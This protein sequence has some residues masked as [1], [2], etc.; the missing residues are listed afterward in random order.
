VT[1]RCTS[2]TT[3]VAAGVV[4]VRDKVKHRTKIVRKGHSYTARRRR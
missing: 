3:K 2:T 4:S 1:D